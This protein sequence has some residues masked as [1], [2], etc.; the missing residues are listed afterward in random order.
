MPQADLLRVACIDGDKRRRPR[1]SCG[2]GAGLGFAAQEG[3]KEGRRSKWSRGC[4]LSTRWGAR[5]EGAAV[6]AVVRR[7]HGASDTTVAPGRRREEE[8]LTGGSPCQ[9]F[10][11][12]QFFRNSSKILAFN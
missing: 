12:F 8:R 4:S 9:G 7:G 3:Q 5:R 10:P 6:E 11:L 2:H 1:L